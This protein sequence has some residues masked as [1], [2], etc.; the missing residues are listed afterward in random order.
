MPR[1]TLAAERGS[2]L[3]TA[4]LVMMLLLIVGMST[5]EVVDSQTRESG[6]ERVRES[7]F[8]LTEGVL[9]TQIYLLSRQWPG[10]LN[11]QWTTCSAAN[12]ADP[13][14]PDEQRL[15]S[16]FQ[17]VDYRGGFTWASEI[18]D[19]TAGTSENFYDDAAVRRGLKY[20]ANGD[21]YLWVRSEGLVRDR[22]RTLVALVKAEELTGTFPRAAVVAGSVS[23]TTS[24]NHQYIDTNGDP[25][26][27]A[28][29]VILRCEDATKS[30]CANWNA[31]KG[32]IGPQKPEA[33][34]EYP[35]ALSPETI[36]QLRERAQAN[37]TYFPNATRSCP[38]GLTGGIVFIEKANLCP[39]YDL[40]AKQS[41]N[42]AQTPGM[43]VIGS[44][45]LELKAPYFGLI[46]HVNG[47]DG[48][49]PEI[50]APQTAFKVHANGWVKGAVVIDGAA[51]LEIG[52]NSGGPGNTGNLLYDPNARNALK[53]F[54]T[55]G[56]V[57][58]SFRE[59]STPAP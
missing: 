36:D 10:T 1:R 4:L 38:E 6:R 49:G 39:A 57:Q 18:Y 56:I 40:S 58:N 32:Q 8:Q 19:N 24:G 5:L 23:I 14:C 34:P 54:G 48:V 33:V 29:R 12:Q 37:G 21:G 44:G 7:S 59:I 42:T 25:N 13:R 41:Y 46:Y 45:Y 30:S 55:A 17:A 43:L 31:S 15:Q 27:E 35:S 51:K 50:K 9:N 3:V 52:S 20:D 47:S 2:A 28:G 16:T 22:R 26:G 11:T 53:T